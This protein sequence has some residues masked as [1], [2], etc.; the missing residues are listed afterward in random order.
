MEA[1]GVRFRTKEE[2]NNGAGEMPGTEGRTKHKVRLWVFR[3]QRRSK[4]DAKAKFLA[5]GLGSGLSRETTV[6]KSQV[7]GSQKGRE[8]EGEKGKRREGRKKEGGKGRERKD[9]CIVLTESKKSAWGVV[10]ERGGEEVW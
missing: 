2:R 3:M 6:H 1:V 10:R 4:G 7:R 8:E 9:D 5:R